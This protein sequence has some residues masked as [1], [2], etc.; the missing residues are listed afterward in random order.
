MLLCQYFTDV[1]RLSFKQLTFLTA[2]YG[3]WRYHK[4][5]FLFIA[6]KYCG[7]LCASQNI[8]FGLCYSLRNMLNIHHQYYQQSHEGIRI[9]ASAIKRTIVLDY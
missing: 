4:K 3:E 1:L 5:L 8:P 9:L 7:A 6:G 2:F